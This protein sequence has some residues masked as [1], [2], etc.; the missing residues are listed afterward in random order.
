MFHCRFRR[1]HKSQADI[2][3]RVLP[4]VLVDFLTPADSI[5]AVI[6]E[7]L[8][9]Q[10]VHL[11][12]CA[13]LMSKVCL[14]LSPS[15]YVCVFMCTSVYIH[16]RTVQCI[17]YTHAHIHILMYVMFVHVCNAQRCSVSCLLYENIV[18]NKSSALLFQH[19]CLSY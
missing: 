12:Q 14:S 6:H 5:S 7:I 15:L 2:I 4:T 16:I 19:R 17:V 13:E 8:S 10:Q 3:I 11:S 1:S 9:P 18:F